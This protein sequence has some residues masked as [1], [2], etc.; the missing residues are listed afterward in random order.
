M[1]SVDVVRVNSPEVVP[2]AAT[3][4]ETGARAEEAA[5]GGGVGV[6]AG[7]GAETSSLGVV[8][9]VGIAPLPPYSF[10]S[11]DHSQHLLR[12]VS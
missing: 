4:T 5:T 12:S 8:E 1:S 9:G 7:F 3:A 11:S 6:D 2:A 10:S